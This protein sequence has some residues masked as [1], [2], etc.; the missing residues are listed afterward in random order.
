MD[1]LILYTLLSAVNLFFFLYKKG[2][3]NRYRNVLV[4]GH[5]VSL[6]L[7]FLAIVLKTK[8]GLSL[9]SGWGDRLIIVSTFISG[10]SIFALHYRN[11]RVGARLYFFIYFLYPILTA[12]FYTT[13]AIM[14]VLIGAPLVFGLL[15]P[16]VSYR[17]TKYE[18]REWGGVLAPKR[19]RLIK[20]STFTE[21]EIGR[22]YH[23]F[24]LTDTYEG[25]KIINTNADSVTALVF[26]NGKQEKIVF[27]K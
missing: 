21:K 16:Q 13:D 5:G 15:I 17:D 8:F 26:V 4:P 2:S 1:L 10:E 20:I 6:L 11:L 27:M 3:C 12:L 25:L 22:S 9:R 23:Q 19:V 7:L 14:G 24:L 18:L